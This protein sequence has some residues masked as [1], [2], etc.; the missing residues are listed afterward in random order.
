M[1][2]EYLNHF[3]EVGKASRQS[4]NFVNHNDIDFV[5]LYVFKLALILLLVQICLSMDLQTNRSQP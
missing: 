4:V 1:A 3:G 5:I 2:F